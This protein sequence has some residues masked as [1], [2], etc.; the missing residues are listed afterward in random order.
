MKKFLYLAIMALTVGFFASC[1]AGSNSSDYYKNG[2]EPQIDYDKATV[3]GKK[4]DNKT[5]K[6]WCWTMTTTVLDKTTSA[7]EYLWGTEFDLVAVCEAEMYAFSLA[8]KILDA[9]ASY[10]YIQTPDQDPEE[11]HK[12]NDKN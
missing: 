3:N 6:C 4:Y 7:E 9:K 12:H 10:T 11:C 1:S 5:W 2:K 8:N